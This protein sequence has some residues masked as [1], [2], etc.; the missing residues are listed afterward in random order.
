MPKVYLLGAGPG[1]P[2]LLTL[3]AKA[4][5]ETGRGGLRYWP[6]VL[7]GLLPPDA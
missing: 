6:S 3:K 1:D 5:L 2:G 4:V 7:P